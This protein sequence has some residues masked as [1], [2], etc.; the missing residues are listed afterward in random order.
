MNHLLLYTRPY[1]PSG[2]FPPLGLVG[3]MVPYDRGE[4]YETRLDILNQ[5]GDCTVEVLSS[6]NLPAGASIWVDNPSK[7]VV[8]QWPAFTEPDTEIPVPNGNFEAGY[9][10]SWII[11]NIPMQWT[12][13]VGVGETGQGGVYKNL[14]GR[15]KL[16]SSYLLPVL[17]GYDFDVSGRFNMGDNVSGSIE[18]SIGIEFYGPD[19]YYVS[20]ENGNVVTP[21]TGVGW[22]TSSFTYTAPADGFIRVF[23]DVNRLADN[24]P[25]FFDNIEWDYVGT[26]GS[27]DPYTITLE[28]RITDSAQR[29]ADWEGSVEAI[30]I[31]DYDVP[32]LWTGNHLYS[33]PREAMTALGFSS[34]SLDHVS[35]TPFPKMASV[36]ANGAA[37]CVGSIEDGNNS[38]YFIRWDQDTKT[39]GAV[40]I[41]G[42]VDTGGYLKKSV[43]NADGSWILVVNTPSSYVGQTLNAYEFD[44]VG[45]THRFAYTFPGTSYGANAVKFSPDESQVI[46]IGE[47][48]FNS[49]GPLSVFDIDIVGDSFTLL[50]DPLSLMSSM[51]IDWVGNRLL[52]TSDNGTTGIRVLDATDGSSLAT[53]AIGAKLYRGGLF[54]ADG[55][56]IYGIYGTKLE[57]CSYNGSNT[58]TVTDTI[59]L[60]FAP[61]NMVM[62][63]DRQFLAI[64]PAGHESEPETAYSAIFQLSGGTAT[65][66]TPDLAYMA[67]GTLWTN[68]YNLH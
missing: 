40:P 65:R 32:T 6:T 68:L 42:Y 31:V 64:C 1:P 45:Y 57:V 41:T 16:L 52:T 24:N 36:A 53:L 34:F 55:L 12:I 20:E 25:V 60:G 7:E 49:G 37:M 8:I 47:G 51:D 35:I 46:V 50:F 66:I 27:E 15:D 54:S 38:Y 14:A 23:V 10:N 18:A 22:Q 9:D 62:S 19:L 58:I 48:G 29:T 5:I 39:Y 2:E 63:S 30:L 3:T 33:G 59:E 56:W 61:R 43:V 67:D 21:D 11:N 4:E 17:E 28:L 13:E 26:T 44:G